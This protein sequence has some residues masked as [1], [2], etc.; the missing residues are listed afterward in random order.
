VNKS[1]LDSVVFIAYAVA[2]SEPLT[3][4]D[5]AEQSGLPART[6]RFYIARGLLDGPTKAGRAAAYTRDHLARLERIKDLQTGGRTLAEITHL[7]AA[8]D[9]PAMTAAPHAAWYQHMP[10]DDVMVFVRADVS[11]WRM[12]QIRTAVDN[13]AA[14]LQTEPMKGNSPQ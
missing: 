9:G 8:P 11:P 13:L 7:L 3:L 1:L 5:L 4:A 6:I 2:M 12:K 10:H 14:Q